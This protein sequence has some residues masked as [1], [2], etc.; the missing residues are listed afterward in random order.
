MLWD[1][2]RQ[3]WWWWHLASI[4][5]AGHVVVIGV[6]VVDGNMANCDSSLNANTENIRYSIFKT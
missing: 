6:L 2:K 3:W 1:T 5:S 4:V